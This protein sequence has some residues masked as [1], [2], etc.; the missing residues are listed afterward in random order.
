MDLIK[1]LVLSHVTCKHVGLETDGCW[2]HYINKLRLRLD[3]LL[4]PVR[5][6]SHSISSFWLIVRRLLFTRKEFLAVPMVNIYLHDTTNF[7]VRTVKD[8]LSL[9]YQRV[10]CHDEI[11]LGIIEYFGL[12]R[13]IF[14]FPA[15]DIFAQLRVLRGVWWG[16]RA[17]GG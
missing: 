4:S 6:M 14:P 5:I 8:L 7:S 9:L 13:N 1:N 12:F 10:E 17:L 3:Q 2:E 16:H 11:V 15:E